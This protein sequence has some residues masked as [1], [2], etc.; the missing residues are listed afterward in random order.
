MVTS[1]AHSRSVASVI[2]CAVSAFS[3]LHGGRVAV[4][5]A[6]H[7]A[8]RLAAQGWGKADVSRYLFERGRIATEAWRRM[9]IA[10]EI[11]TTYRLPDWVNQAADTGAIPVVE[12]AEH[13]VIF[14]A[15]GDAPIPQHVYFPTWG[16]PACRITMPID[17]PGNYPQAD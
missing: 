1:K 4:L 16:F 7:I 11:A 14:V 8:A 13:I 2:A 17:L 5:L 3:L 15:G 9:W 6:P 12:A 10:K